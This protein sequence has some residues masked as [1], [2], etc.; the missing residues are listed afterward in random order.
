MKRSLFVGTMAALAMLLGAHSPALAQAKIGYVNMQRITAQAPG[1][2]EVSKQLES[3]MTQYQ[4]S[5]QKL[6]TELQQLQTQFERQQATL[7]ASAREQR[8]REIQA[9]FQTSQ[10]QVQQFEERLQRRRSELVSPIMKR[11]SETVEQLRKEGNFAMIFD[12]SSGIVAADP[13]LDLTDR[14]LERLR[15][16]AGRG[17]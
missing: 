13:A 10:Q 17:Q 6:E 15:S 11:I 8:Q 16:G 12:T 14:V 9:K 7:S 3:E 4:D 5:I 1:T 2:A